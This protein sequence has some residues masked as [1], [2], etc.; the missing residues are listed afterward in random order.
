MNFRIA[1]LFPAFPRAL[2]AAL[3]VLGA[4]ASAPAT[5]ATFLVNIGGNTSSLNDDLADANPGNGVCAD[6]NGKCSLR[7][8]IQEANN[9]AGAPHT[10]NFAI[11]VVHVINGGLPTITAPVIISGP[12]MLDGTGNGFKHSCLSF[13][14]VTTAT[15]PEGA[16]GSVV[17]LLSIVNC[18]GDGISANGHGYTFTGNFI[19]V[20]PTG[21]IAMPNTGAGITM[22]SSHVYGNVNTSALDAL[23]QTFPQL[24]VQGSDVQ[25]FVQNLKTKLATLLPDT[26][27]GN[28]IAS[29]QGDGITL[30]SENLGAAF[31]SGNMIGTDITGNVAMGNG[32]SGIRLTGNTFGNVIGPNNTISANGAHGID[33]GGTVYLP[34]FVMGN[35]I[36]IATTVAGQHI[37]NAMSGIFAATKPD[38]TPTNFNPSMLAAF[39]GPG[40]FISDNKGAP[41]S[42]DP[43][44]LPTG[45]AGVFITGV[46]TG[47]KV[48]GN[49]IGMAEIP[50]GTPLQT[51]AYGNAGDGVI[52]TSTGN[53]VSGGNVI[54]GNKRHGVL[55]QTSSNTST[56]ILGNT[57][58]FYSAFP[59]DL[60]LGNGFDGIHNDGAS[61]TFIGGPNAGD[62]NVI[63]G[64]G[65]NGVKIMNGGST[66]GWSILAQRNQIFANARG[67]P[68]AMP[69]PLPPG[70]GV[71]IDLDHTANASDGPHSEFLNSYAN[72]DQSPPVICTGAPGE[73]TQCQGFTAAASSNGMTTFDW[74]IAT[75]GPATF[76]LEFFQIN[77]A[78]DNTATSMTF[79]GEQT[80]STDLTGFVTGCPNGRCTANVP[81]NTAGSYVL[82]NVT[83]VTPLTDQP[84]NLGDWKNNLKCFV[85]DLGII[86][87][88]CNAN[89]SSEFSNVVQMPLSSNANLSN[90]TISNGVLTPVFA[91]ATLSYTDSVANA[92][93][94]VTVTPTVAD[95]SAMVKVNGT[96]VASGSASGAIALAVGMNN[97]NVVVTA[98]DGTTTQA[99]T[100]TVNRAGAA[101][102]NAS[103]SNLTISSG[104]L[105]PA[106]AMNTLNYTDSVVNAVTTVTVTPTAADANAT[107]KVNAVTVASGSASGAIAVAVGMNNINVVVTAQDGTT[108]QNYTIVV[109]RAGA[110]SNNASLS[111]LTISSGTLTP[112]F[113]MNTLGYTDAVGNAVT[114]VTVTPTTADA[115]ATVKVNGTTV[116]SGAA[117]AAINL[118]VGANNIT[119]LVT[120][121][122]G[123]TMQTYTIT[124]NR[125]GALSNN[126]NLS[127]LTISSGT[128]TPAFA[129]NTL[130]YTDSVANAVASATVTPTAA[131]ANATIK[132]NGTT[133]ASGA[134]SGALALAVGMNNVSVVVTAQD[135]TTIQT[136]TIV[137]NRA[138]VLSNN[139]NL[140][141]LTISSGTLTPAFASA[142]L[143]YTDNVANAVTSLSVTPIAADAN[144]T[145]KV[146]GTTV[147]SGAAS[148]AINL[149]VG[150]NNISVAVTAQDGTTVQT[151]A[152]AVNRAGALSNNA[153]LSALTISS[154]TLT[155]AFASNTLAYTDSVANAVASV[156]VTPTA[157]DANATIKVNGTTVASGAASGAIALAVGMNNISVAVTAQDGTTIQT[158]TIAVNR[159]GAL[160]NNAS[161]SNLAI[162]SGTL[163]PAF[164][165]NTL[166][167]T[168]AVANAVTTVTVT[169]TTAD[170]NAT[171]KVNGTT[172]ASGAASGA[173]NLAVGVN[174]ITVAATAQ[175]GTTVQTYTIAVN[176]AGA[177]SNNANLSAL[178]ISSGTLTPAFAGNTLAYTDSVANAVTS[179][180][181]TPTAADANATIKV[182]GT[183]VASG[184]VS[185]A[186][187]L[188]VGA[189]NVSVAVTA[190]DGTTIQTYTIA[191]NRAGALSNN[192][193]LSGLTISSGALTPVFAANTLNY[194]DN[195][196]N[197][198]ASVTVTPTAADAN[199]TIAVNGNAVA[200]GSA[201]GA[202]NLAVGANNVSVVVT[203]QDGTTTQTYTIAVNRAGALSN[204]ANL[205]GLTI[206]SG[207]LSP[208]FAANTLAYTDNVANGIASI[209]VTPTAADA[210]ATV[211][212][213]GTAVASGTASG[214]INLAVGMNAITIVVT[215]QDGTTT[216]TYTITVTR[217]AAVVTTF[218]GTTFTNSGVLSANITGGGQGCSFASAS[219]V[220]PPVASPP[221]VTFPDGLFQF[222]L[223]NCVGSVT[224]HATF[225]TAFSA[226]EQYYKYGPTP[227]SPSAHW[228]TLG[229]TNALTLAGNVA[230]FTIADGGLG[231][232][233]LAVNGTIVDQGGPGVIAV[234]SG[235]GVAPTPTLSQWAQ[236][237][238]MGLLAG[239]GLFAAGR[240]TR[241]HRAR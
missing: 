57:I 132:V 20:D 31:I 90:L 161:L 199:A 178:T 151:Y 170:A 94:S 235:N 30:F 156:T 129:S 138:G 207:A 182:N 79:L 22:S 159:A 220:G 137:V 133:V 68:A 227:G 35:R 19:G 234:V 88:A 59:N 194:S 100:I 120:A 130:N 69:N 128:L 189:N 121:Q 127:G 214:A 108:V 52:I 143:N 230:T 190:Q 91:S 8:A 226:G 217:A 78:N 229:A 204:N 34:N 48:I 177:L 225:P 60:T 124:V 197:A 39:I 32:G 17:T 102:N 110:L 74:T 83:D 233:D 18:S 25:T 113:A 175:D 107:I 7:A 154:G 179:V 123:T 1:R 191:V 44:V 117:S 3:F 104:T 27:T 210:N 180:T 85:G 222:T 77:T 46:S 141:N 112:A 56:H 134:A 224:V 188:V 239:F 21:L 67:N 183:T 238:L 98:Q 40:N 140:S 84:G 198:V 153:N 11:P 219:L 80:V 164:A 28:V 6:A 15:F 160:S 241:L 96:T 119:V 206:S 172:V 173:I 103:L 73:P 71:G 87:S 50:L 89:N 16:T 150:M 157:A 42:T 139:A 70:V 97:I 152:I 93:S 38:S 81:V 211:T 62:F 192:A 169:P 92:V 228:Y 231:D 185:G 114:S 75:H 202:I 135:G 36:G 201:S 53:T 158:Y 125:A 142:T 29:N 176:R 181:V 4:A 54:A 105:T 200:S 205:S 163:T 23:F 76:R 131:D 213:N 14:D 209:S 86:L 24:P 51:N 9:L 236:L 55:V 13:S 99:Y 196:A 66:N 149:A 221:G 12:A 218:T 72:L 126:A 109:N 144:A 203:A 49:T 37:G 116:A 146:N 136:Y 111:S 195:V 212:V 184:A 82:M 216:Q 65:R 232:D 193:T 26:I 223:T 187:N 61:S 41:N 237:M 186:V 64:N 118:V 215:A 106:F 174:N 240:R 155:P 43:D 162:S 166:N 5:A 101:S 95:P 147:A 58:G 47:V 168:D 115:N 63:A 208:A 167:Y 165:A 122:D 10:I 171:V 33:M 45:G 148:G 145:I 2:G